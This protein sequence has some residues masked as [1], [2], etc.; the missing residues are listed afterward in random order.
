MNDLEKKGTLWTLH[1][2]RADERDFEPV[3]VRET[4][5]RPEEISRFFPYAG[6]WY[7]AYEVAFPKE[8]GEKAVAKAGAPRFKMVLSGVQGR[9][10][11]VW[12]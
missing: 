3:Y 6:S 7:R 9:A 10:V 11:L 12:D 2:V 5:L 1:V 4:S 8:A